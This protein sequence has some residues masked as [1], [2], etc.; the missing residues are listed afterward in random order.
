MEKFGKKNA[1][2]ACTPP[3]RPT[4]SL[5]AREDLVLPAAFNDVSP[6]ARELQPLRFEHRNEVPR[7]LCAFFDLSRFN[8]IRKM[9]WLIAD[10]GA[11]RSLYY[12]KF[13]RRE[14]VV[15]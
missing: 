12:Q 15:A 13:L 11:P 9:L 1:S 2:P 5:V 6:L 14:I 8:T 10:H 7:F 4:S 3:F